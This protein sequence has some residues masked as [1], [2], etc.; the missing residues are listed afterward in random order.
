MKGARYR[1]K[2]NLPLLLKKWRG[3]EG[4]MSAQS[5]KNGIIPIYFHHFFSSKRNVKVHKIVYLLMAIFIHSVLEI[6]I[7]KIY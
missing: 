2:T 7:H 4:V 5:V 6:R 3:E 1:R